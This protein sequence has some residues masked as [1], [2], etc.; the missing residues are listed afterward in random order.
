MPKLRSTRRI[1]VPAE[2]V[3]QAGIEPGEEYACY[4]VDGYIT[5]IKK[6]PGAA[7]GILE[8]IKAKVSAPDE[9]SLLSAIV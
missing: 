4:A 6:T 9:E 3:Q 2:L 7:R 8:H 1:T 5:I